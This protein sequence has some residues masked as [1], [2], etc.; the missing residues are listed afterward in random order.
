MPTSNV[1][2]GFNLS[3]IGFLAAAWIG[4]MAMPYGWLIKINPLYG[5]EVGLFY[6]NFGHG[7]AGKL[8]RAFIKGAKDQLDEL[9]ER[10]QLEAI[11]HAKERRPHMTIPEFREY[12][13]HY[14][15]LSELY[16]PG[17]KDLCYLWTV[18]QAF[19]MMLV[20]AVPLVFVIFFA[21]GVSDYY[22]HKVHARRRGRKLTTTLYAI[23]PCALAF[24]VILYMFGT[25][26]LVLMKP[27]NNGF[28]YGVCTYMAF[29][30]CFLGF[31]PLILHRFATRE[32]LDEI[33]N[34]NR[35]GEKKFIREY[36]D[37][38]EYGATGGGAQPRPQPQGTHAANIAPD[39]FLVQD[40][41]VATGGAMAPA[42]NVW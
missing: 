36:G 25:Q 29:L 40:F 18:I 13:C 12:A 19:S 31:G 6:V 35:S 32:N 15:T 4:L 22:Y 17:L 24:C 21:G 42:A 37:L 33:R 16:V 8:G 23:A 9:R 34:E 3:I 10:K 2:L 28:P 14:E 27:I 11:M 38:L 7:L 26:F 41:G 30:S 39:P 1:V 20:V 5:C